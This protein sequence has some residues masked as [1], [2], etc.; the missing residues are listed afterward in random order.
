MA[1]ENDLI[2]C[3]TGRIYASPIPNGAP[4]KPRPSVRP[5]NQNILLSSM[6]I[7]EL[8]STEIDGAPHSTPPVPSIP[9]CKCNFDVD[10]YQAS[11]RRLERE[12]STHY[13]ISMFSWL[14]VI[15]RN[16]SKE[17]LMHLLGQNRN[18]SELIRSNSVRFV[19]TS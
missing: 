6:S 3:S 12:Y 15:G 5:T 10:F 13:E 2:P 4:F 8:S 18:R 7:D 19:A 11:M 16:K 1:I 17:V 9:V 14:L